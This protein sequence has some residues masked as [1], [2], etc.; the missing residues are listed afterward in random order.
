M[1]AVT[2]MA[3]DTIA[4]MK[5]PGERGVLAGEPGRLA[6]PKLHCRGCGHPVPKGRRNWCGDACIEQQKIRNQPAYARQRVLER[7]N[8]ICATCG[9]DCVALERAIGIWLACDW[10]ITR[11]GAHAVSEHSMGE[12]FARAQRRR[13]FANRFGVRMI[14]SWAQLPS[15]HYSTLV[16]FV[17]GGGGCGLD[18]LRTL[19]VCCHKNATRALA[20]RRAEARKAATH[21]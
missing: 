21:G 12:P 6:V 11:N 18:N 19:C 17:E 8:G 13:K 20:K 9:R 1:V 15:W 5:R 10:S 2:E 14:G 4:T 7:D 16:Q 3:Q